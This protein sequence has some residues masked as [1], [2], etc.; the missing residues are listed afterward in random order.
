MIDARTEEI[1]GVPFHAVTG[2]QAVTAVAAA[3]GRGE[4][5]IIVTPNLDF[6]HR[7]LHSP[8]FRRLLSEADLRTADGMPVVWAGRLAGRPLPGRVTGVDLT[9][10]LCAATAEAGHAVFLIGGAPGDAAACA[11]RL[12]ATIPGLRIAGIDDGVVDLP[13]GRSRA[14]ALAARIRASRARLVLVGLGSPKQE[15]LM[16]VLRPSLPGCW[17]AG[18]GASFAF[19]AGSR[20]RAAPVLGRLGLEWLHRLAS[21][22]R[23]LVNRYLVQGLPTALRL[24]GWALARRFRN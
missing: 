5:G 3:L 17:F 6:L 21:D 7:A 9:P 23:H 12:T 14:A 13:P 18:V 24:A 22:P 19:I 15:A 10:A 16:R 1:L 11:A 20:T 8:A 4:G 2:A